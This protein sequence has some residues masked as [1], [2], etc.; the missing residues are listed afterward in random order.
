[1]LETLNDYSGLFSLLAVIASV[2]IPLFTYFL[3]S[4]ND[5][6]TELRRFNAEQQTYKN[7]LDSFRSEGSPFPMS[8]VERLKQSRIRF[9][10]K[11]SQRKL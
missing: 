11:Q 3:Q 6:I 1:M 7:E 4:K 8:E 5:K 10:E 2:T 9:L